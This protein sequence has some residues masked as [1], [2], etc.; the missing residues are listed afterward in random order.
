MTRDDVIRIAATIWNTGSFYPIPSS[1]DLERF[2]E[3]VAAAER[4]ACE[5]LCKVI[6]REIDDTHGLATYCS[7]A[8]RARGEA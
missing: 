5:K 6:A 8:I 1:D 7:E 2:A 4:E 3:L